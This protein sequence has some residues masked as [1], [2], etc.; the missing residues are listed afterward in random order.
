M[1]FLDNYFTTLNV[2]NQLPLPYKNIAN[3]VQK[4]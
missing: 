1:H 3:F 2:K 4:F